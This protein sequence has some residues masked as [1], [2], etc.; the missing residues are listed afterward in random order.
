M[1]G[2]IF[3]LFSYAMVYKLTI[4]FIFLFF[5]GSC[6]D[7]SIVSDSERHFGDVCYTLVI[8]R[9]F[10]N[11][12]LLGVVVVEITF[13]DLDLAHPRPIRMRL[14][15]KDVIVDEDDLGVSEAD[16]PNFCSK[17]RNFALV[18]FSSWYNWLRLLLLLEFEPRKLCKLASLLALGRANGSGFT[19]AWKIKW[20]NIKILCSLMVFNNTLKN[21]SQVF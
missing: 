1:F 13:E 5:F 12:H 16:V 20:R 2:Y 14:F 18:S 9:V 8:W 15:L 19:I 21:A 11:H 6:F 17:S 7:S 4:F 3:V 10:F